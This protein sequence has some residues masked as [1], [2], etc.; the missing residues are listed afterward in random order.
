[1]I[2]LKDIN[3]LCY[4]Y[5]NYFSVADRLAR[6]DGFGT[7]YYF[8]P[9]TIN[10]YPDHKPLDIGRNVES[11]IKVKEWA[12]CIHHVDLIVFCDSHEP[13][14]QLYFESIG[15]KVF[16]CRRACELE[17]NKGLLLDTQK[18][19]G[20]PVGIYYK[21]IGIDALDDFLKGIENVYVKSELRGD[22]ETWKHK[23][24][25]LSKGELIRMRNHMGPYQSQENY[26]VVDPVESIAEIGVDTFCIDGKYPH[27]VFTGIE[28]KD[29]AFIGCITE[30][31]SLPIQLKDVTDKLSD[32][33]NGLS[34]RGA[35]SN[36]VIIGKDKRGYCI[37]LTNRFPQPPSDLYMELYINFPQIIWQVACGIVPDIEYKYKWGVQLIIKSELAKTDP[38]PI[39]VPEEY[40]K[41]VKI[42]NLVIDE[43]GTWN[44]VPLD[45]AMCEIGS[46]VGFGNTMKE[47][48]N[49]AKKVADS[50]QGFDIK[51]DADCLE[52]AQEQINNLK[53]IG[54]DYLSS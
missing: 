20:L 42:K 40:K 51:I 25:A 46:C 14:L 35:H 36:E 49:M 53:K 52:K 11:V 30:Y 44:Y 32:I 48:I 33:F 26:I 10:G 45:I 41:Y 8:C 6:E 50:I 21:M 15:K 19:I 2:N 13:E 4:D 23:N 54:I 47:A 37:D 3:V 43:D 29:S 7:V 22:M 18:E 5:G 27:N 28:V 9:K 1:M 12:E 17:H 31:N 24:Y 39:I 34:Y 38:S 16:G